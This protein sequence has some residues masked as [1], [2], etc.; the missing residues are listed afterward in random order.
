MISTK[1]LVEFGKLKLRILSEL[2]Q[3]GATLIKSKKRL[4]D[5]SDDSGETA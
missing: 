4:R 1:S 3:V 2:P 5:C